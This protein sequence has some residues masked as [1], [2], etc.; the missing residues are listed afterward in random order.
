[1]SE[2]CLNDPCFEVCSPKFEW[3]R[4]R[5]SGWQFGEQGLIDAIVERLPTI[6]QSA[7]EIGGGDGGE[8]P[9][10]LEN[11]YLNGWDLTI[12]ERDAENLFKL[13]SKYFEAKCFGEYS[14]DDACGM[15][16]ECGV[17]VID[18][19]GEDSVI[20]QDLLEWC[21]I[22]VL[23]VEHYDLCGP[24]VTAGEL[25]LCLPVPRWLLGMRLGIPEGGH[26]IVQTPYQQLDIIAE[27]GG[28]VPVARTRVNSI[29]VASDLIGNL[30]DV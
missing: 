2:V 26:F 1:M 24:Y 5:R 27:A 11:M 9:L 23:V 17:A 15:P 22:D 4:D 6:K 29:Y 16:L 19:D 13:Q 18:V 8:L 3:L 10:T 20:M 21:E 28:M 14:I 7:V 30:Q 12:Y 25:E